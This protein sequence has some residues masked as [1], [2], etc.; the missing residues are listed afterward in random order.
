MVL[1][2][3]AVV[4]GSMFTV[5]ETVLEVLDASPANRC[6]RLTIVIRRS[7]RQQA[8]IVQRDDAVVSSKEPDRANGDAVG[9][10]RHRCQAEV[11]GRGRAYRGSKGDRLA[12]RG[13]AAARGQRRRGRQRLRA[14]A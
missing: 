12:A 1:A 3:R 9:F 8:G 14:G 5:C 4:V 13:G 10:E 7:A 2:P 11:I 6:R